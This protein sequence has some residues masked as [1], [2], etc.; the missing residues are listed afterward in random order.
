MELMSIAPKTQKSIEFTDYIHETYITEDA[1]FPSYLWARKSG[2]DPNT[3]NGAESFHAHYNSQF[4]SSHPNVY[5]VINVLQQIQVETNTKCNAINKNIWNISRKVT[6]EKQEYLKTCR[7]KYMSSEI[8][9]LA[10]IQRMG[11]T[12]PGKEI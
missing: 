10:Y 11:V 7:D 12:F 2:N 1:I 6:L 3:T 8:K 9:V 5:Q 4:Y